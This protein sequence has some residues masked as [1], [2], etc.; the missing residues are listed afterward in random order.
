MEGNSGCLVEDYDGLEH[1]VTISD[2]GCGYEI[3]CHKESE[4]ILES[5]DEGVQRRCPKLYI[6]IDPHVSLILNLLE[7]SWVRHLI[8]LGNT[9]WISSKTS[10][11]RLSSHPDS[12]TTQISAT[13][14]SQSAVFQ[15]GETEII[16]RIEH[17]V[18][19]IA[20]VSVDHLERLVMVKY[21]PGDYFK[22]HHDGAFRTH[23]VLLYLNDVDGG[24]TVFPE[25]KIAV[26]PVGNS[27]LYW[28]NTT[29][30]GVADFRMVHAGVCPK[31]GTKYA[32]NCF[33]N[34]EPVRTQ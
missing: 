20:G 33:F 4:L 3:R 2:D 23:T 18:S 1:V 32:V 10:T 27:A 15:H 14:R 13:R 34:V 12:Y 16:A 28:K 17:R 6:S 31:S 26:R 30:D 11:G 5:P 21:S 24:E 9:R 7:P 29:E 25:L 22:E 8:D 19:L